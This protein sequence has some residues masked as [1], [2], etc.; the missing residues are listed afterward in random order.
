MVHSVY[1]APCGRN[2]LTLSKFRDEF[3]PETWKLSSS[4]WWYA[5][6]IEQNLAISR[7]LDRFLSCGGGKEEAISPI[8][9]QGS[10]IPSI[11]E[12]QLGLRSGEIS[13][14]GLQIGLAGDFDL[15][16]GV[17][18]LNAKLEFRQPGSADGWVEEIGGL[19]R[20]DRLN[21]LVA[22]KGR[23]NW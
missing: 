17:P 19:P 14:G 2:S 20:D 13:R 3:D 18:E 6:V 9:M 12:E 21:D 4:I 5:A 1:P 22:N 16:R 15:S 23:I 7:A 11:V 10:E 8:D